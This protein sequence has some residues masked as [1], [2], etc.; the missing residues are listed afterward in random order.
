MV[1]TAVGSLS[2]KLILKANEI[3]GMA[4]FRHFFQLKMRCLKGVIL[5]SGKL[6]H[7]VEGEQVGY[8]QV[9]DQLI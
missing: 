9:R 2:A 7:V 6:I 3:P 1:N 4:V 8:N 5:D